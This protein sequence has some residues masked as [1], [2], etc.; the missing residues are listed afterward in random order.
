V[1]RSSSSAGRPD[2]DAT[3]AF[4][5]FGSTSE[6]LLPRLVGTPLRFAVSALA[7]GRV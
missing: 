2:L 5:H 1:Q 4:V 3:R 7:C 6:C